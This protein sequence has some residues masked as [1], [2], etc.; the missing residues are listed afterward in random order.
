MKTPAE[1]LQIVSKIT[2]KPGW[3]I[4]TGMAKGKDAR[5]YIQLEVSAET[6]AALCPFTGTRTGWRG[7]KHYLSPHMC[8]QEIVGAVFGAIRAAEEHEMRE[9]FR[10]RSASIYN[11]HLDPDELV[12]FAKKRANLCLRD[13]AMTMQEPSHV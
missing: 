9:W 2:Y 12:S 1:I 4:L 5:P 8:T 13:N 11:P 6:E 10:Y 7:A 3:A